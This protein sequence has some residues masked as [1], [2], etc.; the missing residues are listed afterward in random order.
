MHDL[1]D[2]V[3]EDRADAARGRADVASRLAESLQVEAQPAGF[4]FFFCA[5]EETTAGAEGAGKV[6]IYFSNFLQLLA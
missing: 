6:N 4:G 2:R 1:D 5:P 3:N